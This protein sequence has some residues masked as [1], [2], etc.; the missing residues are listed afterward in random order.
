MFEGG[1]TVALVAALAPLAL[2]ENPETICGRGAPATTFSFLP[3]PLNHIWGSGLYLGNPQTVAMRAEA[4]A[5]AD[6]NKCVMLQIATFCGRY[7]GQYNSVVDIWL[8]FG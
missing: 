1:P 3:L 6:N 5:G 4:S 2:L 8:T 7:F